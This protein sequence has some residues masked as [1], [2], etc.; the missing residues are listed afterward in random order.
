MALSIPM[1]LLVPSLQPPHLLVRPGFALF[2]LAGVL[3]HLPLLPDFTLERPRGLALPQLWLCLLL[4]YL[5]IPL[6]L[7]FMF[8]GSRF[9]R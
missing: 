7:S 8:A 9:F 4:V 1:S 6:F 2:F 3:G 5:K